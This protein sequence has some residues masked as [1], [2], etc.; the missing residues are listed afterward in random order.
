MSAGR[1]AGAP[2]EDLLPAALRTKR[3]AG[4]RYRIVS[5]A[6]ARDGVKEAVSTR[7]RFETG[8]EAVW[9]E[10]MF[11]EEVP[12]RAPLLLRTLLA[13]PVR[14][15]GEKGRAGATVRC[16]YSGGAKLTKRVKSV[17]APRSLRFEVIEQR[18]GIEDCIRTLGGSYEIKSC[19]EG[20]EVVLT[21][22]YEAYLRPR[23]LWR[24][25]EAA[26]VSQLHRHILRGISA[27]ILGRSRVGRK[28]ARRPH[29][30]ESDIA[31][32]GF[33]CTISQSRS[34]H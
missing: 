18:L 22:N 21:T 20:S 11:Y 9:E 32:G 3:E 17:E 23:A 4:P 12:G 6:C 24:R 14:T 31:A 5:W 8:A 28:E 1:D 29:A 25:V 13:E 30:A 26:L 33:A 16:V 15:E 19:G 2:A 10:L 7:V 27:A 34:R